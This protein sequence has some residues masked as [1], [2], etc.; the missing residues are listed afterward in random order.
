MAYPTAVATWG[1]SPAVRI[2]KQVMQQAK[3][4]EGDSVEFEVQAPGIIVI[5]AAVLPR[6]LED[7]VAGITRENRHSEPN[8]GDPQ[9]NEIW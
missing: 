8:W 4:H 9:G 2:P 5:R 3:L 7:L 1:N 6:T